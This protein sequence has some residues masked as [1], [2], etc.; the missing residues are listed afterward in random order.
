MPQCLGQ[1]LLMPSESSMLS[2]H[3][4]TR[5]KSKY[6]LYNDDD[7]D[8]NDD[9][10]YDHDFFMSLIDMTPPNVAIST[11]YQAYRLGLSQQAWI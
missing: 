2:S 4:S 10:D 11:I 1:N 8:H 7:H 9:Y 6:T 3:R 5:S